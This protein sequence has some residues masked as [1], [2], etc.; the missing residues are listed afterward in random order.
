MDIRL[1]PDGRSFVQHQIINVEPLPS[2]V[3]GVPA[4]SFLIPLSRNQVDLSSIQITGYNQGS[5]SLSTKPMAVV[6]KGGKVYTGTLID[7]TDSR[8]TLDVNSSRI[9]IR[10]YDDITD[11]Q[12]I[13]GLI[14]SGPIPA[15]L[16]IS[17][18]TTGISSSVV[19]SLNILSASQ[20]VQLTS[21]LLVTNNT[22]NDIVDAHFEVVTAEQANMPYYAKASAFNAETLTPAAPVET[23]TGSIYV[24][25]GTYDILS[26]FEASI[27]IIDMTLAQDMDIKAVYVID[28]P[29]GS[30]N[31]VYTIQWKS[32]ADL[33]PGT[34]NIY[35]DGVLEATTQIGSIGQGQVIDN[36]LLMIPSVYAKG[37]TT[38]VESNSTNNTGGNNTSRASVTLTGV[39][40]NTL[41]EQISVY[42]R[43]N[44]GS[45]RVTV[46]SNIGMQ[47]I[48]D[49]NYIEFPYTLGP[50]S[51]MPYNIGFTIA[52]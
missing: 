2:N 39:I 4:N 23:S 17:Y 29:N 26:G 28:A 13:L 1:F 16:D 15:T 31:A 18:V 25:E 43:Y 46:T 34:L 22:P 42:L 10:D 27:P 50:K 40:T 8:V 36:P 44:V 24:V 11:P 37:T 33:P 12:Y 5:I 9:I 32:P 30:A 45:G 35:K 7:Y 51:N 19:H 20:Q 3:P 6:H 48:R 52:Y 38:R 14:S 49:G 21:D 47:P 41:N